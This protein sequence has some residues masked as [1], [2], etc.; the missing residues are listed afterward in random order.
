MVVQVDAVVV[1][2][3]A[4]VARIAYEV[5]PFAVGDSSLPPVVV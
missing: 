5:V 2:S 3:I 1:Q 4:D